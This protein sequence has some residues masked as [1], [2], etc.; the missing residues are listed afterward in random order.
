M[1]LIDK[2]ALVAEIERLKKKNDTYNKPSHI[3][4]VCYKEILSAID[5][6]KVKEVDLGKEIDKI[7]DVIPGKREDIEYIA[8]YF[9]ELGLKAQQ[10]IDIG[11]TNIDKVIEENC[12]DP[13]SKEAKLFKESYY[14]AL[15]QLKAQKG[16]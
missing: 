14:M 9:F 2:D 4:D 3:A 7:D 1:N 10:N 6:F 8:K 12:G 5:T 13:N 15:E 16:E 11:I